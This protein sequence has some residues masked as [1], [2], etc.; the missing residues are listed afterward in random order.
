MLLARTAIREAILDG[1]IPNNFQEAYELMKVEGKK[2][3]LKVVEEIPEPVIVPNNGPLP[4]LPANE[5]IE[6]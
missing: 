3:G 1:L 2:L 5:S 4:I 6:S